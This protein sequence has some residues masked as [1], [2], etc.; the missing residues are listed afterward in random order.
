MVVM[1]DNRAAGSVEVSECGSCGAP[2]LWLKHERTGRAAPINTGF[3]ENGNILI[4]RTA[5]TYRIVPSDERVIYRG[6]L[7]TSHFVT[8]PQ[9]KTWAKGNGKGG[10]G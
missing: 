5:R 8:C 3:S 1:M 9:A 10:R 2:V 7:H 4:H 6:W